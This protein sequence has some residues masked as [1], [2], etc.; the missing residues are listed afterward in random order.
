L[1]SYVK[2]VQTATATAT[3]TVEIWEGIKRSSKL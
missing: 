2:G 3:A 1:A